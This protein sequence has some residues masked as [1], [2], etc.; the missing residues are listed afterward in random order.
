MLAAT[1]LQTYTSVPTFFVGL[2]AFLILMIALGW[3]V[4]MGSGRPHNK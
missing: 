1:L 4:G 3:V 2:G